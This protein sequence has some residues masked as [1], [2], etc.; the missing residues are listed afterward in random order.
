MPAF[1]AL[2]LLCKLIYR[3][4]A[5][6]TAL[7][8]L[9]LYKGR[10]VRFACISPRTLAPYPYGFLLADDSLR[11]LK[12]SYLSASGFYAQLKTLDFTKVAFFA[13]SH[14]PL[15]R[16]RHTRMPYCSLTTHFVCYANSFVGKWLHCWETRS[17]IFNI[18]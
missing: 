7:T 10:V 1:D 3:R 12:Q 11:L 14:L 13:S 2:R 6:T 9:N 4:A 17:T 18:R 15:S 16:S 5:S 8:T